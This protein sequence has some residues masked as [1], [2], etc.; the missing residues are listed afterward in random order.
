MRELYNDSHLLVAATHSLF[1]H[2]YTLQ[3]DVEKAGRAN[4]LAFRILGYLVRMRP[5]DR[6]KDGI[7]TATQYLRCLVNDI[8]MAP[9]TFVPFC[10]FFIRKPIR[11]SLISFLLALLSSGTV[12]ES[13]RKILTLSDQ[14]NILPSARTSTKLFCE[15][16]MVRSPTPHSG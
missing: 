12:Y 10:L 13:L 6:S 2:R 9:S 4:S 8:E 14:L 3:G 5:N 1:S 16:T 7:Q 15:N 11:L